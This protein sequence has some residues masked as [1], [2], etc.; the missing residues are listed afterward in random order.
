MAAKS[1]SAGSTVL[2]LPA[3][4]SAILLSGCGVIAGQNN[5]GVGEWVGALF[6]IIFLTGLASQPG[7][8]FFPNLPITF[9][10]ILVA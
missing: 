8:G 4:L 3:I 2:F 7:R 9:V 1:R 6:A 10:L 5:F